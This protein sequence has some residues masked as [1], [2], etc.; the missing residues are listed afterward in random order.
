MKALLINPEF[1]TTYWGFDYAL[2]LVGKKSAFPPLGL[3]T[4]SALLPESWDRDL[5]DLNAGDSLTNADL[6][7]A[8]LVMV[9]GML[10]QKKAVHRV[11]NQAKARGKR[12]VVGGPYVSTS[13]AEI[14]QADHIF[15]GE[16]EM[17]LPQFVED[18]ARGQAQHVYQAPKD[19]PQLL[20][21]PIPDYGLFDFDKYSSMP[22]QFSRGCPFKCEF[23]DI[24]VIYGNVPRTK[25]GDAFVA[26]INELHRLGWTGSVFIV[27]DNFI[28]N[29]KH[30]RTLVPKL[31]VWQDQHGHPFNFFTEA[32]VNLAEDEIL[33]DCMR[34]ASFKKVFLGIETPEPASLRE[35][36]K[37]QNVRQN[38][39]TSVEK[40][41]RSG[42]EV[43]AGFIVGFDSDPE[44]IFQ[45]Q[46]DFIQD[47][48]IPLAMVGILTALPDTPLYHRLEEAGR[49]IA[50]SD[51][52]NTGGGLNFEPVMGSK[53]LIEGY[54]S[55][56]ETVYQPAKYYERVLK[57]LDRLPPLLRP[58]RRE[59]SIGKGLAVLG[60]IMLTLGVVDSGRREFWRFV[61]QVARN[62][63]SRFVQA[64]TN[65]VMGYHI[66]RHNADLGF[67]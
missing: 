15:I 43:M 37:T 27:D 24:I 35:T 66:R 29:L 42:L 20:Q 9:T 13:M 18:L 57:Y 50:E 28:G 1:P 53:R 41:E 58:E 6:D 39:L 4:V 21:V 56:V 49:L 3:A 7:W 65:A 10:I 47:S 5:L 32:S 52:N 45:R 64:M 51:G 14:P 12:V 17:T 59:F 62:H 2:N 40:I 67:Q 36:R 33:L 31:V 46:I 38:L 44:D 48:A 26:E 60:R 11:V 19:L 16:A 23:C 34:R 54:R 61:Y 25:D 22:A 8:D 55:I 30:V 63:R